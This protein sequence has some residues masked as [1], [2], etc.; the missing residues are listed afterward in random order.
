MDR[1]SKLSETLTGQ[2]LTTA[3]RALYER[4]A[5]ACGLKD[6]DPLW[7]A[8]VVLGHYERLYD[9]IPQRIEAAADART[10]AVR[11]SLDA[12]L[13]RERTAIAARLAA[14]VERIVAASLR[15]QVRL[16]LAKSLAFAILAMLA[17]ATCCFVGGAWMGR[18]RAD[19]AA[20]KR[21]AWTD[22]AAGATAKALVDTGGAGL[23]E[24]CSAR[25]GRFMVDDQKIATCSVKGALLGKVALP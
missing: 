22:T 21:F 15:D 10:R 7:T 18:T 14:G 2:P 19:A 13:E 12:H 17:L 24:A 1:I 5:R 9:A 25:G 8:M 11:E 20:A 4:L 16:K 23:L 3:Q 6:D